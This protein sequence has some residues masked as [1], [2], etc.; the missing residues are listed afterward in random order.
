MQR[1]H[2]RRGFS[3]SHQKVVLEIDFSG[4]LWGYTELTLVPNN[5]NLKTI[6]LHARQCTIHFVTVASHQADFVHGDPLANVNISTPQDCHTYPELKRKI[7]TALAE[8]DE[9]EL[10]IAIP[11]EV[12]LRQVGQSGHSTASGILSETATPE[13]QTPG[14]SFQA[15]TGPE[16]MPIVVHI[17]YSLRNPIDGIQ[18]VLPTDAYP[19]RVPHAFTTPSSPDAAR[20]WVPCI[21]NPWEKCTWE[22][23]FVVPRYLEEPDP[24]QQSADRKSVV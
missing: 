16:F 22:F 8:G 23:E 14:P 20:C 19:Y 12:P 24:V 15:P 7:Y 3:I 21:D 2:A 4:C 1:E 10:S 11:K 9:G 18:F 17:E 13:P 6:H 5:A